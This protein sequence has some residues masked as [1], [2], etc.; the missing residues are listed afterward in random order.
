MRRLFLM[1]YQIDYYKGDKWIGAYSSPA[2]A[3]MC[4]VLRE[5]LERGYVCRVS[6]VEPS[7]KG[8]YT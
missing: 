2:F 1:R 8:I 5:Q 7:D 3:R 4:V 6:V